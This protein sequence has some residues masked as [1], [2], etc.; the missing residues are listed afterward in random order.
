MSTVPKP[1]QG[2]RAKKCRTRDKQLK[3]AILV[4]GPNIRTVSTT[5]A[6]VERESRCMGVEPSEVESPT[7]APA[8]QPYP[9]DNH[10][11][12]PFVYVIG[13]NLDLVGGIC[14]HKGV[15]RMKERG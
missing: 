13:G 3:V 2:K 6:D 1:K 12:R 11:C 14:F 10:C 9:A 5:E 8:F 7:W 15:C 4:I